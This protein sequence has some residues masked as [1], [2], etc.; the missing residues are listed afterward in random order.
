MITT[1]LLSIIAV[2]PLVVWLIFFWLRDYQKKEPAFWIILTILLGGVSAFLALYT[3]TSFH[4]LFPV[5]AEKIYSIDIFSLS[6]VS[7]LEE[8]FK[9][10][11]VFLI[12][13]INKDFDEPIDFMIYMVFSAIGFATIENLVA[14][15]ASNTMILEGI[16]ISLMR[17]ITADLLHII[18]SGMI[19]FFWALSFAKRKVIYLHLG[20]I[21]AMVYHTIYN[22]MLTS[23]QMGNLAYNLLFIIVSAII[24]ISLFT[25]VFEFK[26]NFKKL[27]Y[28]TR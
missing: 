25:K 27:D 20:I 13:K 22:L 21:I 19:G 8:G 15:F 7:I 2:L 24:I 4:S 5:L 14:V 16:Q 6:I 26:I 28:E 23:L 1:I 17:M 12:F 9:F 18:A 11:V 3:Q 10:L